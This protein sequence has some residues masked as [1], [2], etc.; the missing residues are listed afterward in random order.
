MTKASVSVENFVKTIFQ[1]KPETISGVKFGLISEKLGISQAATTDMAKKLAVRDLVR[2]ER[3][4][5]IH[6]TEQ[7]E[8]LALSVIRKHRLWETLLHNVLGLS[9]HEIHREA[10]NLEHQ[11]S[12]FLAERI[13]D[14]LGNPK[15]DPH[16]D[17]IPDIKGEI[18]P[19]KDHMMLSDATASKKYLI[20]RLSNSDEEFLDFCV[21]NSILPG[22][23]ILV[24]SQFSQT[25]MTEVYVNK[26]RLL[27]N[28]KFTKTIF[29]K[30]I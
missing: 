20:M 19:L 21:N 25:K 3:Y 17:P 16:G 27:L 26:T 30:T 5:G 1:A 18:D 4:Q 24:E 11:T 9:L 29:V 28:E 6:L 7:G 14:Y 2:Y 23:E 13:C 10:E 12:D 15:F 22:M 8:R